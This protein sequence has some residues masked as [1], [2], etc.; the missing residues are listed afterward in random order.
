MQWKTLPYLDSIDRKDIKPVYAHYNSLTLAQIVQPMMHYSTNFIANQLALNLS[1]ELAGAPASP[2]KIAQVYQQALRKQFG[3]QDFTIEE[4]AGLSR[5]NQLSPQ[6]LIQL[7]N[8]FSPWRELL[9]EVVPNVYAKSGTLMGVNAL[10]GY[11]KQA[12]NQWWP[13][14]FMINQPVTYA[15]RNQLAQELSQ[16][17]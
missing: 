9:P 12:N 7:L 16:V 11:V 10:A 8:A 3:W 17:K 1:V 14:V 15:Y 5:Q 13:F 4:G 2:Q 6:Q